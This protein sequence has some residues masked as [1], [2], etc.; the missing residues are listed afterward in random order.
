MSYQLEKIIIGCFAAFVPKGTAIGENTVDSGFYP[1]DEED[2]E[3]WKTLGCVLDSSFEAV[4]EPGEADYCPDAVNGGYYK[5]EENN[6]VKD[7]I[8]MTLKCSSE[9]F[10][11]LAWGMKTAPVDGTPVTPFADKLRAVE[12]WLNFEQ[13]DQNNVKKVMAVVYGRFSLDAAPSWTKDRTKPAFKFEVIPSPIASVEP[14]NIA[15][16]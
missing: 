8:K 11:Q 12:G 5:E 15:P 13:R 2:L 3:N 14:K 7:I 16:V 9:M 1:E 4:N 6:I 10:W